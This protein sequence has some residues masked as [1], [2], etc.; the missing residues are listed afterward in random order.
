MAC[1]FLAYVAGW[2]V[3]IDIDM[4]KTERNRMCPL[5]M[6]KMAALTP[7]ERPRRRPRGPE[8]SSSR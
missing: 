1:R 3:K 5:D 4:R 6:A 2:I 8:P 7:G